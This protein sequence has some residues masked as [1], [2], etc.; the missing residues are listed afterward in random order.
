MRRRGA[1]EGSGAAPGFVRTH[2]HCWSAE[3]SREG[4]ARVHRGDGDTLAACAA[5]CQ[6]DA[7]CAHFDFAAGRGICRLYHGAPK[8]VMSRGGFAAYVRIE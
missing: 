6:A 3:R 5:R 7:A 1:A 8:M 2:A 4:A